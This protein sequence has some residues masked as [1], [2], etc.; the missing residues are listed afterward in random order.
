MVIGSNHGHMM[1][2]SQT[3]VDAAVAKTYNI[4][5]TSLHDH[6]VMITAAQFASLKT[7]ATLNIQSSSDGTHT[8]TITVMCLT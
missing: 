7:G 4:M 5:G 8:H 6:T 3:E 1:I 2:V